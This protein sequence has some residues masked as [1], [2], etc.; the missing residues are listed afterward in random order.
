VFSAIALILMGTL[1]SVGAILAA[2][3]VTRWL[4]LPLATVFRYVTTSR[5]L[6]RHRQR[7]GLTCSLIAMVLCGAVGFVKVPDRFRVEGVVEPRDYAVIHMKT[8]GFVQQALDSGIR[9]GPDGPALIEATSPELETQRDQLRAEYRQLQVNWQFA[10]TEEPAAAQIMA[11]KR[12][13]LE[14]QIERT[15]QKLAA[16]ALASP[17]PGVWIAADSER[18]P[19]MYVNQGQRIGVVADLDHVRIRAVAS[20]QVASRLIEDAKPHVEMRVNGRPEIT[21]SGRIETIIPAG[22]ERLPSAAL[23]YAAGG[24]TRIDL[25]DPSGRQAAEPFFEILVTPAFSKSMTLRPGQTLLLRFE[26]TAKPLLVQGW[27]TLLQLFQRRR[28]V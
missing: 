27:R 9:I 22:Q 15:R 5:E 4:L 12:A 11:E 16:L 6:V 3:L 20:Q 19:G 23:G 24:A 1:A 18:Y 10:H 17:I 7:V 25:D 14:E 13:A 28:T 2:L 8:A 26:T 21:L